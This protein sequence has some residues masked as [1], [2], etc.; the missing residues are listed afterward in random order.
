MGELYP[1]ETLARGVAAL[2][3]AAE[4]ASGTVQT[5]I[6]MEADRLR[7]AQLTLESTLASNRYKLSGQ[8]TDRAAAEQKLGSASTLATRLVES[9]VVGANGRGDLEVKTTAL[10]APGLKAALAPGE[11]AYEDDMNRGGFSR[12]DSDQ[13]SGFYPGSYGLALNPGQSGRVAYTVSA[14]PGHHFTRVE[15][16][17]VVFRGLST[18][19]VKVRG[20]VHQIGGGS[21]LDDRER[22]YDLTPMVGGAERFTITFASRNSTDAPVLCL[23]HWALRGAV[24]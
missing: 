12:R 17:K 22:V 24:E 9:R 15:L 14:Q 2:D 21:R 18:I 19:E 20:A 3:R 1:P 7:L 16:H 10:V 6:Q 5:R 4:S 11:F 23:D 13:L 8:D